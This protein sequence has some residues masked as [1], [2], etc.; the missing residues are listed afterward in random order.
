MAPV[1]PGGPSAVG[2]LPTAV[3]GRLELLQGLPCCGRASRFA[4]AR[5]LSTRPS[6]KGHSGPWSPLARS[7]AVGMRG[8]ARGADGPVSRTRE[9]LEIS[10]PG[11]G[12]PVLSMRYASA[13][14][15]RAPDGYVVIEDRPTRAPPPVPCTH[16]AA[17]V[18]SALCR[19][20]GPCAWKACETHALASPKQKTTTPPPEVM[21]SFSRLSR[22]FHFGGL[23]VRSHY[24]C[25]DAGARF[26]P[27]FP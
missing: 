9:S 10:A 22:L 25:M 7:T 2:P 18:S 1:R 27:G 3:G 15:L 8:R 6:F 4:F 26:S 24:F 23:G 5:V 19:G 16:I 11:H 21:T 13:R 14:S 17:A 12:V 20:L